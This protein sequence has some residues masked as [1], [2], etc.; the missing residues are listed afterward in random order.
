MPL[1]MAEG[2]VALL[3][4]MLGL[5]DWSLSERLRVVDDEA[6]SICRLVCWC[7]EREYEPRSAGGDGEKDME[8]VYEW[9]EDDI[10][11]LESFEL[12]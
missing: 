10:F 11:F 1:G 6:A 7:M 5:V 12:G 9:W 3:P 2:P 4:F 8:A